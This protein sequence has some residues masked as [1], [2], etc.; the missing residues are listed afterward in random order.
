MREISIHSIDVQQQYRLHPVL[1]FGSQSRQ[2]NFRNNYFR[3]FFGV[4]MRI[5]C[6]FHREKLYI[7]TDVSSLVASRKLNSSRK[8][9]WKDQ[10][11]PNRLV[12]LTI[13]WFE[14]ILNDFLFSFLLMWH[15]LNLP[16][17]LDVW[18]DDCNYSCDKSAVKWTAKKQIKIF[19]LETVSD[20]IRVIQFDLINE[21]WLHANPLL[22]KS[23]KASNCVNQII[24]MIN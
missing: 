4:K 15:K 5:V 24:N 14:R 16:E 19:N 3:Y 21:A 11:W 13:T 20:R 22:W 17:R 18:Q 12:M 9:Y 6:F 7:G 23:N 1:R 10:T 2:R 8:F